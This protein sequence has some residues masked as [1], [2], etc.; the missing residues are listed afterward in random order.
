M[1]P[2]L[3]TFYYAMIIS[4]ILL[5][6]FAI[7]YLGSLSTKMDRLVRLVLRM[8]TEKFIVYSSFLATL[9]GI[10]AASAGWAVREVGRQPWVIYGL[11]QY[12]QVITSDP[13][14]P[15]FSL[16]I[17]AVELGIFLAGIV[18]FYFIPTKSLREMEVIR[19]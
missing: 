17:I 13:I 1:Q 10:I 15:V 2:L 16:L 4:G 5:F 19:G 12:Q 9:L 18:A 11:V 7:A 3:T 8:P 14:T 6:V